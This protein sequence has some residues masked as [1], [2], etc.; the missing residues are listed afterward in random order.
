MGKMAFQEPAKMDVYIS[1]DSFVKGH[2]QTKS[3]IKI[4][5]RVNGNIS[6]SGNVYVGSDALVDGNISG[7]EVQLAGIVR[8]NIN[9]SG[10][11]RIFSSAKLIGDVKAISVEIENGAQYKGNM[12]IGGHIDENAIG[13]AAEPSAPAAKEPAG[14]AKPDE[15]AQ[16]PIAAVKVSAPAAKEPEKA[17]GNGQPQK[18][19]INVF[20][21]NSSKK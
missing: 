11:L 21:G 2:L 17:S 19:V 6:A 12:A 16:E 18:S 5:G 3:N 1:A 4:D 8:G 13:K 14:E 9:V 7:A 20:K 15:K 10:S